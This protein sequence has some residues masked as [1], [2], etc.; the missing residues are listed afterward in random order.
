MTDSSGAGGAEIVTENKT[1]AD[2]REDLEISKENPKLDALL[3]RKKENGLQKRNLKQKFEAL[4]KIRESFKTEETE[5]L[6][7]FVHF[8]VT[9]RPEAFRELIEHMKFLC[10]SQEADGVISALPVQE[11]GADNVENDEIVTENKTLEKLEEE[12]RPSFFVPLIPHTK[13]SNDRNETGRKV[14]KKQNINSENYDKG[15]DVQKKKE[16]CKFLKF[17]KCRHGLSGKN[18]SQ[19]KECSYNHPPVCREH[20]EWGKCYNNRCGKFHLKICRE[21]MNYQ[22]CSYGDNCKFW[23]PT[24]LKDFRM[25]HERKDHYA[26]EEITSE[27]KNS[28][29]FY[30]KNHSYL[31]QQG[32][33]RQ[34][35]FLDLNQGQNSQRTFLELERQKKIAEIVRILEQ[36]KQ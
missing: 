2:V 19:E 9:A 28:R 26:K 12:R 29:V 24:G 17:G 33:L 8:K 23:H 6:E 3:D 13:S 7:T 34:N 10:L 20:E 16:I 22:C 18:P 25:D 5:E 14:Q 1:L 36:N 27:L 35:P 21:Y 4:E 32:N 30:G 15:A 11:S 31:R